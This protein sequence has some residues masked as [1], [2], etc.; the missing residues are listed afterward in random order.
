MIKKNEK[1]IIN[2][3]WEYYKKEEDEFFNPKKSTEGY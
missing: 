3:F 1:N 2:V